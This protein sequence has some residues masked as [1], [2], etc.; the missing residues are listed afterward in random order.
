MPTWIT[1]SHSARKLDLS[2]SSASQL[3]DR[4]SNPNRLDNLP[5]FETLDNAGAPSWENNITVWAWNSK[6]RTLQLGNFIRWNYTV[7]H[8]FCDYSRARLIICAHD[9]LE[10]CSLAGT[11]LSQVSHPWFAGGHTVHTDSANNYVV[12]CSSSDSVLTICSEK[13]RIVK[14]WRIPSKLYQ[15]N[16][17]LDSGSDVRLH[18][19]CNDQQ[20]SHLNSAFPTPHFL[21]VTCF[22]QGSIV[23][24]YADGLTEELVSGFVGCH[25]ARLTRNGDIYFSDTPSGKIIWLDASGMHLS[26]CDLNTTWLHDAIELPHD[27]YACAVGDSNELRI[28]ERSSGVTVGSYSM[29]EF[30][31]TPCLLNSWEF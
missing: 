6:T 25:G 21:L 11:M 26:E 15:T 14:M 20:I 31:A 13:L 8:A 23:K 27:L 4:F 12:A 2:R 1:L 3:K 19:I 17:N 18:Y 22:I 9:K 5:P 7:N 24:V 29:A 10:I 28:I 16:Y 30:G